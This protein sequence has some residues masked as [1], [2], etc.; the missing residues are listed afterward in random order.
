[1]SHT[2]GPVDKQGLLQ[3]QGHLRNIMAGFPVT[4]KEYTE[5]ES[6]NQV[7]VW[8]TSQA[9][10]YH[11]VKDDGTDEKE[12][13]FSIEYV[14]IFAMDESGETIIR[15]LEFLDSNVTEKLMVS[16]KRERK[17]REVVK[18]VECLSS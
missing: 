10:F 5:S 6:G 17:S 13:L 15:M 2:T 9:I 12:L 18:H 3:W 11:V 4:G 14:F 8:T 1:M 7:T 16:I